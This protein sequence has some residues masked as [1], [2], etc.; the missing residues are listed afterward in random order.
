M[1]GEPTRVLV[2]SNGRTGSMNLYDNWMR[3]SQTGST[4]CQV[5]EAGGGQAD[6]ASTRIRN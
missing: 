2:T 5:Q 3:K 6:A 1:V 4:C